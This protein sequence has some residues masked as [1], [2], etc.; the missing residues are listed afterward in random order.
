MECRGVSMI[1]SSGADFFLGRQK[2]FHQGQ[3]QNKSSPWVQQGGAEYLF[4]FYAS[5]ESFFDQGQKHT[6]SPGTYLEGAYALPH[7]DLN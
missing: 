1:F 5:H 3:N 7:I 6:I 4:V 2:Y